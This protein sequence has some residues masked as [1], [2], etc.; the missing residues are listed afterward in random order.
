MR[1]VFTSNQPIVMSSKPRPMETT[2]HHVTGTQVVSNFCLG[3]VVQRWVSAEHGLKLRPLF[4]LSFCIS[5]HRF[6]LNLEIRKL[7]GKIYE[8]IF[9]SLQIALEN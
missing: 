5:M 3:P 1:I 6:I 7:P 9:S 2:T 8:K 4:Y